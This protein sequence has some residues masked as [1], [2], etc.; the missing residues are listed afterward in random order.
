[1]LRPIIGQIKSRHVTVSMVNHTD[2]S[3][4][5]KQPKSH[6]IWDVLKTYWAT[7]G[8]IKFIL[9]ALGIF[10]SFFALEYFKKRL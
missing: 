4:S 7:N 6:V 10:G 5:R 9:T 1:M 3:S 2:L 8:Q